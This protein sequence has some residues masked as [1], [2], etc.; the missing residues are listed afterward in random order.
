MFEI[1]VGAGSRLVTEEEGGRAWQGSGVS[2]GETRAGFRDAATLEYF[3]Y[4][5]RT[6]FE[7]SA[8]KYFVGAVEG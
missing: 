4:K 8:E 2:L 6:L 3:M 5:H 7:S 1:K